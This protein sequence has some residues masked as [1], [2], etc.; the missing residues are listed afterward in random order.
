LSTVKRDGL[1]VDLIEEPFPKGDWKALAAFRGKSPLPILLDESVQNAADARRALRGRL[2]RGV[3]VK[4]AKS[5]LTEGKEIVDLCATERGALMIGCMAES[6][7]GLAASVQFAMGTG[8]FDHADL[9]ADLLLKPVP[10]RGGYLRKGPEL[11]LPKNAPAGL[12]A[13]MGR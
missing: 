2:A 1:P 10:V 8:A 11:L 5:G 7:L 9:D 4:L 13:G 3:N 6:S 12:G